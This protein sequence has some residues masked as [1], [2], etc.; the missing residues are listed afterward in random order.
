MAFLKLFLHVLPRL[1]PGLWVTLALGVG[2]TGI[3]AI[4]GLMLTLLAVSRFAPA[5]LLVAGYVEVLRNTPLLVQMFFIFLGLP[6]LGIRVSAFDAA[7]ISLALQHAAFFSEIY[8]GGWLAVSKRSSEAAKALGLGYWKTVWLVILPQAIAK[9]LPAIT[10]EVVQIVKDTS[11]ASTIAVGELTLRGG[12]LA[13]QT[14]SETLAFVA[15]AFYYLCVTGVVT[16][17]AH[18]IEKRIRFA[19]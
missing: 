9:V 7:L 14:A 11:V 12:T 18:V 8:R 17:V 19:E 4:A 5:R 15:V 1:L 6:F 3:A 2:A 10:N 13:G 16:A